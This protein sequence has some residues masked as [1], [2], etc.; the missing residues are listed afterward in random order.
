MA[1]PGAASRGNPIAFN[2]GTMARLRLAEQSQLEALIHRRTEI[3]MAIRELETYQ[4]WDRKHP[5]WEKWGRTGRA[6]ARRRRRF[7]KADPG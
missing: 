3:D 7:G 5:Q 4:A 6:S 2:L 1:L